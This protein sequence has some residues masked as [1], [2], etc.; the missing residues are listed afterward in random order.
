MQAGPAGPAG[1]DQSGNVNPSSGPGGVRDEAR[2]GE[3]SQPGR[4]QPE[5]GRPV[6]A[7][8]SYPPGAIG[9]P[10]TSAPEAALA[11]A[12]ASLGLPILPDRPP[13]NAQ[14]AMPPANE[15]PMGRMPFDLGAM[16]TMSTMNTPGNMPGNQAN[17]V[18]NTLPGRMPM[19]GMSTSTA[20][21]Q[22][23]RQ[24]PRQQ[25]SSGVR[26][27]VSGSG[28]MPAVM[29]TMPDMPRARA[30]MATL[31]AHGAYPAWWS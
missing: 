27:A 5:R 4:S 20:M 19:T 22:P 14:F 31:S 16:S 17:S 9:H 13:N 7:L 21:P 10:A 2:G 6:G 15:P 11:E 3:R 18:S 12:A 29:T 26:P 24:T 1:P 25:A 28:S 8:N 23:P 30:S